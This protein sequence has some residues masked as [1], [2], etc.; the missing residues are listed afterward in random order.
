MEPSKPKPKEICLASKRFR[1]GFLLFFVPLFLLLLPLCFHRSDV[2]RFGPYDRNYFLILAVVALLAVCGGVVLGMLCHRSRSYKPSFFG[3]FGLLAIVLVVGAGEIFVR[4][5][6]NNSFATYEEWGHRKSALF[7]FEA[8][9]LNKWETTTK[10]LDG[11]SVRASYSTDARGFRTHRSGSSW[12]NSEG[13]RVFVMGGSSAFG[14]G[15]NDDQTWPHLLENHL[16]D[17]LGPSEVSV[18]NAANNGQN[19]LQMFL[20]YFLRIQQ[21]R[22]DVLL[23]Y[24]N[25]NDVAGAKLSGDFIWIEEDVLFSN[26]MEEYVSKIVPK[27]NFYAQLLLVHYLK[28]WWSSDSGADSNKKN[29][30][31]ERTLSAQ[32]QSSVEANGQRYV[33]NLEVLADMCR[34]RGTRLILVSFL[35]DEARIRPIYKVGITRHNELLRKFAASEGLALLD[36]EREFSSVSDKA[37][38]FHED[39]YHP[40]RQGARYIA[41]TLAPLLIPMIS[42]S[43]P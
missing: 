23:Y 22:P 18:I 4:C 35:F 29:E 32:E 8:K 38:Y 41:E 24:E 20:R 3:L 34:R 1:Q 15:L 16:Q 7:G 17:A 33:R 42:S 25:I 11:T 43:A 37:V 26:T 31:L 10:L 2:P 40:T 36:L 19:S 21:H 30:S 5:F 13:A 27:K 39:H 14:F 28:Q 12:E 9:P 6:Y